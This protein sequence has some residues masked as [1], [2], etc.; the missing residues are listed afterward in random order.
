MRQTEESQRQ[1][2]AETKERRRGPFCWR[3]ASSHYKPLELFGGS[4]REVEPP[5]STAQMCQ[6]ENR[7]KHPDLLHFLMGLIVGSSDGKGS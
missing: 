5:E 3:R 4:V 1:R 2:N 6:G 7:R